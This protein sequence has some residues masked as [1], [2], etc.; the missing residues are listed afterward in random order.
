MFKK[1]SKNS[2]QLIV[3]STKDPSADEMREYLSSQY[4]DYE[5]NKSDIEAAIYW[6][7]SLNYDGQWSN[8]YSAASTSEYTPGPIEAAPVPGGDIEY[9]YL[10][11]DIMYDTNELVN[12]DKTKSP[13]RF[14]STSGGNFDGGTFDMDDD[15]DDDD[16]EYVF[17]IKKS[18]LE[19]EENGEINTDHLEQKMS[20]FLKKITK[21]SIRKFSYDLEKTK[22]LEETT[23]DMMYGSL[24]DK[25]AK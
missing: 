2:F 22:Q 7:A 25:Y 4:G 9:T 6:F 10:L 13:D 14:I 1:I 15:G 8:L 3:E 18:Q 12:L 24:V 21:K 20:E 11:Y 23:V 17:R 19:V 16:D 5:E